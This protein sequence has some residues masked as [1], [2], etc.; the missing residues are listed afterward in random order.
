MPNTTQPGEAN[1]WLSNIVRQSGLRRGEAS[2][3]IRGYGS[4]RGLARRF[5]LGVYG[6]LIFCMF[7]LTCP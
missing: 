5:T 3:V 6:L 4:I 7:V 1:W 2:L